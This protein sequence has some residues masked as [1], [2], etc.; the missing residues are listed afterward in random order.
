[1][2]DAAPKWLKLGELRLREV[3]H[4]IALGGF[5]IGHQTD[6]GVTGREVAHHQ[7]SAER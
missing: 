3:D 2:D 1:M 7:A 5:V 6:N 4:V